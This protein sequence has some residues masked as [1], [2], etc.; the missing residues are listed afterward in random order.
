[1]IWARAGE[2]NNKAQQATTTRARLRKRDD[3]NITILLGISNSP[4]GSSM[5]CDRAG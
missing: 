5:N 1:V 2:M 4:Q 3:V